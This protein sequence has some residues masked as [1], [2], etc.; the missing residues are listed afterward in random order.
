MVVTTPGRSASGPLVL[1]ASFRVWVVGV[2]AA[3]FA[4]APDGDDPTI[5]HAAHV[6]AIVVVVLGLVGA[7]AAFVRP[8]GR[9]FVSGEGGPIRTKTGVAPP[10]L[11]PMALLGVVVAEGLFVAVRISS[12]GDAGDVGFTGMSAVLAVAL[13]DVIWCRRLSGRPT[14]ARWTVIALA[15]A[16]VLL[17]V[18]TVLVPLARTRERDHRACVL[19]ESVKACKARG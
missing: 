17:V 13:V 4:V 6:A 1:R 9:R 7:G 8:G 18:V 2:I 10:G 15:Y 19:T 14:A 3:P 12:A 16:A 5:S 11:I